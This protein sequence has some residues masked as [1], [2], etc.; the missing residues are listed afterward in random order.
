MPIIIKLVILAVAVFVGA[1]IIPGVTIDSPT[2]L[3]VVAIV[4][5]IINT[6]IKPVLVILT[7]PLTI[8]TLGIFL[9]LLN[10]VLVLL[11]SLLVPGFQVDSFLAAILFSIVVSLTSSL[12]SKVT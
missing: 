4:L 7:L 10:G 5:A 11:V 12:L 8:L 3:A 1:Y 6:F 2:S 9:L